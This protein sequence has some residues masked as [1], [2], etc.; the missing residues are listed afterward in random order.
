MIYVYV[1][2]VRHDYARNEHVVQANGHVALQCV[3]IRNGRADRIREIEKSLE[4]DRIFFD[5]RWRE[6]IFDVQVQHTLLRQVHRRGAA[7]VKCNQIAVRGKNLQAEEH[8]RA[9]WELMRG[10]ERKL[11]G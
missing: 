8:L 6:K 5:R 10:S 7:P 1:A 11:L 4:S 2:A 9:I 3:H